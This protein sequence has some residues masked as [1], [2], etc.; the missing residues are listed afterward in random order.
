MELSKT[1]AE[2]IC[3]APT[4][5]GGGGEENGEV[6]RGQSGNGIDGVS[7]TLADLR[8][9]A[10]DTNG[11]EIDMKKVGEECNRKIER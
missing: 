8:T 11:K 10:K 9:Q 2:V 1:K 7:Q 6:G 5:L 4:A 3:P